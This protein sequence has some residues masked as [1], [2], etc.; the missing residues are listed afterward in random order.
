[1]VAEDAKDRAHCPEQV[2]RGQHLRLA[3]GDRRSPPRARR[4]QTIPPDN[5]G[6]QERRLRGAIQETLA[7]TRKSGGVVMGRGG[8][9]VLRT[10]PWA[11]HVR[12]GGAREARTEQGA[13]PEGVEHDVAFLRQESEENARIDYVRRAHGVD[14]SDPDLDDLIL[15]SPVVPLDTCFELIAIAARARVHQPHERAQS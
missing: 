2:F 10:L 14:P 12:R 7:G 5:L 9:I 3:E 4:R 13:R 15:D 8:M 11:L 6:F 1:M